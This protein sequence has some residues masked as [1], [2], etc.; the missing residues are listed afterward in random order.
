ME[1][2]YLKNT[3]ENQSGANMSYKE[4]LT[5][6]NIEN[7]LK[8]SKNIPVLEELILEKAENLRT[9]ACLNPKQTLKKASLLSQ[10]KLNQELLRIKKSVDSFLD[11]QENEIPETPSIRYWCFIDNFRF[12]KNFH[13]AGY[14]LPDKILLM[15][16]RKEIIFPGIAHEYCHHA[17]YSVIPDLLKSKIGEYK[18]EAYILFEFPDY[19]GKYRTFTEGH[20]RGAER[21]ISSAYAEQN[22]NLFTCA[23]K[24]LDIEELRDCYSW[25]CRAF[26]KKPNSQ[27]RKI[28][29]GYPYFASR[30]EKPVPHAIGNAFF[31][32][33]EREHGPKIYAEAIRQFNGH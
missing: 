30:F 32:I 27:V 23:I 21:H 26:R 20:A 17:Q 33:M 5:S 1:S 10:E 28:N 7:F 31:S 14:C 8:Q 3:A 11:L 18:E 22:G 9:I 29:T 4:K 15:P 25:L 2:L 13:Y 6:E 12:R 19:E 24:S 16:K